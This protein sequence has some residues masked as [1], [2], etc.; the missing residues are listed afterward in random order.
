VP[1]PDGGAGGPDGKKVLQQI[2]EQTGGRFFLVG[3]SHQLDNIFKEI[4]KELRSQYN[5]G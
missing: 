1:P 2:A 5:I 3:T 4:E